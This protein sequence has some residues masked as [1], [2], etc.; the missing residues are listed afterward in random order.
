MDAASALAAPA[1]NATL[2][3]GPARVPGEVAMSL[4][5]RLDA[6]RARRMAIPE[7]RDA[8]TETLAELTSIGAGGTALQPGDP[9][10]DFLLPDTE[11]RFVAR[12]DRLAA[13]PAVVAFFRG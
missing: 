1:P 5:E 11:G 9:F 10:P 3:G 4:R 12:D 2:W 6:E 7:V 8:V 13:G